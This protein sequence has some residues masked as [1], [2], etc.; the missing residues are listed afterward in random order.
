MWLIA[1]PEKL[2]PKAR[3]ALQQPANEVFLSAASVWECAIKQKHGRLP[4]PGDPA[5]FLAQQ[6]AAHGIA[7]L[8][9]DEDAVAQI[10]KLPDH[11]RDPFDR[12]LVCQAII[13]GMSIVTPDEGIAR[14]PVSLLW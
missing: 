7:A 6:R 10:G 1:E 14:Y 11:H 5:R 4:L 9:I 13:G 3:A 12:I 2:T 8:P